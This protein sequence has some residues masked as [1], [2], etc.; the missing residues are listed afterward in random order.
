MVGI[1]VGRVEIA[2]ADA[3]HVIRNRRR[4]GAVAFLFL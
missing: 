3:Y 2:R 1:D 4:P